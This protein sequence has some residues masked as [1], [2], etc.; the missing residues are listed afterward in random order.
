LS[1][2]ESSRLHDTP[3]PLRQMPPEDWA[4]PFRRLLG[5]TIKSAGGVAPT[6]VE[7]TVDGVPFYFRSRHGDWR[8]EIGEGEQRWGYGGGGEPSPAEVASMLAK[9]FELW[10][11]A[12]PGATEGA[13][14]R[15]RISALIS[16]RRERLSRIDDATLSELIGHVR[17]LVPDPNSDL[18]PFLAEWLFRPAPAL[19]GVAPAELLAEPAAGLQPVKT[20]LSQ[21]F[22]GVY[23]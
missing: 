13:H 21:C 22:Y 6:Q 11:V 1:E 4:T 5:V 15:A 2:E 3:S 10:R 8:I 16:E 20:L 9:S 12:R 19:G 17:S 14:A 23:V 18:L 7:G